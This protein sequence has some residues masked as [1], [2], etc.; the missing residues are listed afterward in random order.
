MSFTQYELAYLKSQSLGRLGTIGPNGP[1]VRPTGFALNDDGTIDIGGPDNS[2]SQK[3][4]NL[5]KNPAVSFVVDDMTPDEPGAVKPGWGRGV[6]VRGHAE[7]LTGIDPP[8]GGEF[9][10]RE[11]IRIHPHWIHSWHLDADELNN[12]RKVA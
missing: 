8:Y 10:S 11:V 12:R 4:R 7:L 6:E 9:F 3:W 1:Q 2:K 5:A